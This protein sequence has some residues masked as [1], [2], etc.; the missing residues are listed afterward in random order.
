MSET[1]TVTLTDFL[2]ARYAEEEAAARLTIADRKRMFDDEPDEPNFVFRDWPDHPGPGI[3]IVGAERVL[4]ECE[5]KRRIIEGYRIDSYNT[6][7][8]GCGDD[9][10]WKA[11]GWALRLL[12]LPYADHPD[13]RPEWRP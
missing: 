9:C 12:T 1:Q 4:A 5:A 7:W 3:V 13:Y 2:L 6:P 11:L 8:Q 10:E